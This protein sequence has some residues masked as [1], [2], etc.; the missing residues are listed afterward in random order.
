MEYPVQQILELA[1]A[2]QRQNNE[3][4]KE[5][6][7]VLGLENQIIGYKFSNK[8]LIIFSAETIIDLKLMVL[9]SKD[10]KV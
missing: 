10:Y 6:V 3:Y 2:A 4:L 9:F 7:P 8:L 5:N 1:C